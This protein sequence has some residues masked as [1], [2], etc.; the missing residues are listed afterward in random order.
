VDLAFLLSNVTKVRHGG[1]FPLVGG[2]GIFTVMTTWKRGRAELAAKLRSASYPIDLFM[3][4][5]PA[6]RPLRVPGTAVFMTSDPGVTPVVLLHHYKHNKV[7][8]EKVLLLSV[9]TEALSTSMSM[10]PKRLRMPS[11]M[12]FTAPAL[13]MSAMKSS[14]WPPAV[15]ISSTTFAASSL[16]A[17]V[18]TA[19]AAPQTWR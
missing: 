2:G 13:A 10:R 9:R 15:R 18:L 8:H 17:R 12:A 3:Q 11:A 1:W 19:T 6:Q 5:L 4:E 14:A 16:D 7:L